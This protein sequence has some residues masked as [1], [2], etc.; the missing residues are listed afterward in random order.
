MPKAR[1][2]DNSKLAISNGHQ[3]SLLP[4]NATPGQEKQ[5]GRGRTSRQN[6]ILL[7]FGDALCFLI[8]VSIGSNQHGEGFNLVNSLWLAIPFAAGWFLVAPF[9]GAF[10]SEFASNPPG[11]AKRTA[12]AW[13]AAW[14]VAMFLRWLLVDRTTSV[15]FSSFLSFSLVTLIFNTILLLIWRWPFAWNNS[16][17]QR[18][19]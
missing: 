7:V 11:M 1:R 10:K 9:I 14:P 6:I 5:R 18:G 12:L 15:T 19:I 16:L 2:S 8:F 13:L 17:R 3:P 4:E